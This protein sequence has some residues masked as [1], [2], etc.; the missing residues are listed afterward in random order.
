MGPI[1]AFWHLSNLLLPAVMMGL[2]CAGLAKLVWRRALRSVPYRRLATWA[3]GAGVA[4]L[5]VGWAAFGRDGRMASYAL[6]VVSTA[7][8]LAWAGFRPRR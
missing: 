3:T 4:A 5:L 7:A 2:L 8:A 6:L 1:D